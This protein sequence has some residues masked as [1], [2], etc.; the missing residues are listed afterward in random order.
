MLPLG[1]RS[2]AEGAKYY[3]H[4]LAVPMRGKS[5]TC[6]MLTQKNWRSVT[7]KAGGRPANENRSVAAHQHGQAIAKERSC[8]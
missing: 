2:S 4:G 5:A 3:R 1:N 6:R 8:S 7:A